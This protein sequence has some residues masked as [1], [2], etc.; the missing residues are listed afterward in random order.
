MRDRNA[1]GARGPSGIRRE[2][3]STKEPKLSMPIVRYIERT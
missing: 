1:G 3:H 2:D